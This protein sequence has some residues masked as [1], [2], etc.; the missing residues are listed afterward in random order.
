MEN[1]M[2]PE[3]RTR[4]RALLIKHEGLREFPYTDSTGRVKIGV[5]RNLTSRG[6]S[7]AEAFILL[8]DDMMF[9]YDKLSSSFP[10]FNDLD[11]NR[12]AALI[13]MAFPLGWNGFLEF[14]NMINALEKQDY[15]LAALC[16][17]QSRWASQE[18]QRAVD[19]AAIIRSGDINAV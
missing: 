11:E 8:D 4:L 13:D 2:L 12:R 19:L 15:A 18:Q 14:R 9:F 3:I 10:W 7:E 1:G 5:G 17:L 16:M 6:I